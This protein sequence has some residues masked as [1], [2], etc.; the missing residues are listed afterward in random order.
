MSSK[1]TVVDMP[2]LGIFSMCNQKMNKMIDSLIKGDEFK[3][4]K[5]QHKSLI[6][7]KC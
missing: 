2:K 6:Q 5:I 1:E 7:K 4:N 3:A